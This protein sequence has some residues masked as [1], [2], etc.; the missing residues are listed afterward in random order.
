MGALRLPL[1]HWKICSA[2]AVVMMS[3]VWLI[4][5]SAPRSFLGVSPLFG[6]EF[7]RAFLAGLFA[8]PVPLV[9]TGLVF[10]GFYAFA[11]SGAE[12][13][14]RRAVLAGVLHSLVQLA[15]AI[16]MARFIVVP[17]LTMDTSLLGIV[18]RLLVTSIFFAWLIP[19]GLLAIYL[20]VANIA[21][22]LH[23]QEVFSAQAI[24]DRKAFLRIRVNRDGITI[25]PIGLRKICRSWRSAMG[26]ALADRRMSIWKKLVRAAIAPLVTPEDE[27]EVQ[28]GAT[29]LLVPARKLEPHLIEDPIV[30]PRKERFR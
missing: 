24:D 18:F 13:K 6:A 9:M 2:L 5:T 12:G 19:G 28:K 30:I 25:Y 22:G 14:P 17:I 26:A 29:H 23:G 21:F 16:L 3:L 8:S 20:L 15:A 11:S 4:E 10:L 7:I 1:K 27:I